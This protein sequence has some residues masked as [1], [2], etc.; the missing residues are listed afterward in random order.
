[1]TRIWERLY[2]RCLAEAKAKPLEISPAPN[3]YVVEFEFDRGLGVSVFLPATCALSAQLKAWSLFPEH[4][5]RA[6]STT[7]Y[8][9]DYCE[10]NWETGG[11][12]V[13]KRHKVETIPPFL[14]EELEK[15]RSREET[16]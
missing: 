3:L 5:C 14:I 13:A 12:F 16:E 10:V 15:E 7:V 2:V 1:M 11:C 9:A 4:R 6:L 8:S